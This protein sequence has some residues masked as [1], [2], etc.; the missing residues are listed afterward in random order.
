MVQMRQYAINEVHPETKED[1]DLGVPGEEG[2][3][4]LG[5]FPLESCPM[6]LASRVKCSAQTLGRRT[7]PV[8]APPIPS[9]YNKIYF[10]YQNEYVS[11][12]LK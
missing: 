7:F 4:Q 12:K 2:S 11:I 5:P 10:L 1:G 3:E 6:L 9:H 8:L